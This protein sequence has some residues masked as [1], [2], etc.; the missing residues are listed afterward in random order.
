MVENKSSLKSIRLLEQ[1]KQDDG[2]VG[3]AVA[4]AL[5][6]ECASMDNCSACSV[7]T[8]NRMGKLIVQ[9]VNS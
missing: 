8:C 6:V 2:L 9:D 7:E 5:E 3:C 4:H 1:M